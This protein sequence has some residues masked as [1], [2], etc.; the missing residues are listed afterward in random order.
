MKLDPCLAAAPGF[1]PRGRL[2]LAL[3]LAVTGL[4]A[5]CAAV[6]GP[7]WPG[8]RAA[9]AARPL[10]SVYT[11]KTHRQSYFRLDEN[12][13]LVERDGLPFR[14]EKIYHL[15]RTIDPAKTTIIVM[16]PWIDMASNHLSEYYGRI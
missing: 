15:K 1:R 14:D 9:D 5:A 2:L 11:V 10:G 8:A 6:F 7:G 4:L 12:G 16:D 13:G 3:S